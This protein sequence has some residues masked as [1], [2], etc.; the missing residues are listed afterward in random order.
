M[1]TASKQP[2]AQKRGAAA[3]SEGK[4]KKKADV[5]GIKLELASELPPTFTFDL[6]LLQSG[7]GSS[8][9]G[10]IGRLLKGLGVTTDQ[11]YEFREKLVDG[12]V[13]VPKG[14]DPLSVFLQAVIE[15]YGV[16]PGN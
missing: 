2:R 5:F 10:D 11:M 16:S 1:T 9:F 12:K 15:Q 8:S 14:E 3:R 13:T 6:M 4:G 7:D